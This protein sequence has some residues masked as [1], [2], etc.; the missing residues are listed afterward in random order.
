LLP[1]ALI[2]FPYRSNSSATNVSLI[3]LPRRNAAAD[4]YQGL[5]S[6]RCIIGHGSANITHIR[7]I[8]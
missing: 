4:V 7:Y 3:S 8:P 5:L 1:L 6:D 2:R